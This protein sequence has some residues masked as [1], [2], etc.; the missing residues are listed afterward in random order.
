MNRAYP[1]N[2]VIVVDDDKHAIDQFRRVLEPV[3]FAVEAHESAEDLLDNNNS[4]RA[5]CLIIEEDLPGES[6]LELQRRLCAQRVRS[7]IIFVSRDGH[8]RTVVKAI[9]NGAVDYLKKPVLDGT[10]RQAVHRAVQADQQSQRADRGHLQLESRLERLSMRQREVLP[11]ICHGKTN[12]Q[13]AVELGICHKTVWRHRRCVLQKLGA[14][15]EVELMWLFHQHPRLL[16]WVAPSE[17]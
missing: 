9:K 15:G 11:L 6:G 2:K 12:R 13:I 14:K 4:T 7:P 10:L 8:T 3:G 16:S 1:S 17:G 5:A